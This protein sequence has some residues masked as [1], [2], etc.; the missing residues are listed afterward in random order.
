MTKS[1]DNF[2]KFVCIDTVRFLSFYLEF[3]S[4]ISEFTL[5]LEKTFSFEENVKIIWRFS[6]NT[7]SK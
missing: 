5:L 3:L 6:R 7:M 1:L 2:T 4:F